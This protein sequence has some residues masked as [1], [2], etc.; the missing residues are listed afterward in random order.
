MATHNVPD[1][2]SADGVGPVPDS[3][4]RPPPTDGADANP[5]PEDAGG[6][7]ADSAPSATTCDASDSFG[8]PRAIAALNSD[9][10]EDGVWAMPDE[11][12]LFFSS[13]RPGGPSFYNLYRAWRSDR[14]SEN[15][16]WELVGDPI[17]SPAGVQS[18]SL[19]RDGL[20]LFYYTQRDIYVSTRG[21]VTEPFGV[22][23]LVDAIN[24]TKN[25]SDPFLTA[26]DKRLYFTSDRLGSWD[27]YVSTLPELPAALDSVNTPYDEA[28]PV[29]SEDELTL[30]YAHNVPPTQS[31]QHI[32]LARR[33]ALGEPFEP[34]GPVDE[35]NSDTTEY[36]ESLSPDG[37]SLYFVSYRSGNPDFYIAQR[38]PRR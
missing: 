27:L 12:T 4:T 10:I 35:V 22:G 37:C 38:T 18:P 23:R 17:N 24:S 34:V 21:S 9:A 20:Q 16:M 3:S 26:D 8:S 28:A 14:L 6:P 32:W 2:S 5:G 25:E 19:S 11:L 29:L 15:W 30:Y 31:Q 1:A 33:R 36:P 13:K 7:D